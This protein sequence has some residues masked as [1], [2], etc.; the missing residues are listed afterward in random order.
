MRRRNGFAPRCRHHGVCSNFA[1]RG[2]I[3]AA[4]V[5]ASCAAIRRASCAVSRPFNRHSRYRTGPVM[6]RRAGGFLRGPCHYW[7]ALRMWRRSGGPQDS[8]P[9]ATV[10][11]HGRQHAQN[12][13]GPGQQRGN[14]T[15]NESDKGENPVAAIV[16]YEV[17]S[18]SKFLL[19][20]ITKRLQ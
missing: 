13:G 17:I 14:P 19:I 11:E 4:C 18:G 7:R 6:R 2:G 15:S 16:Q 10:S 5:R 3:C 1:F 12:A 8:T 20:C 9:G